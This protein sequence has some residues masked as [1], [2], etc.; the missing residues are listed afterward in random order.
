M[1]DLATLKV[2][3]SG[4]EEKLNSEWE[5]QPKFLLTKNG[6]IEITG[7]YNSPER[8]ANMSDLILHCGS[9]RVSRSDLK[10]VLTPRPTATHKPVPHIQI[11]ELICHEAQNRGYAISKEEYGLNPAGTKLFG[12]LRFHPEGHPEYSRALGFRN[13]H[14]KSM[15]VGLTVGLSILCCDNMA[16]GGETTIHRK[17]TSGIE[18]EGLIPQAF[19][20]LEHQ[21]IRLE[22]D[23]QGLKIQALSISSAKL[24]TVK[25]AEKGAINSSDIIPVLQ[26]F[27]K[28]RHEEFRD[29]NKWSLYNSFTEV[30]K[31]YTPARADQ[32]Y[33]KLGQLFDLS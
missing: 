9:E 28:P 31:K 12:V 6:L 14:D 27:R 3:Y 1:G 30:C 8:K 26:E 5:P 10:D 18:I 15:A 4:L 24:M 33:R 16:F 2:A 29:R 21:F 25:A 20:N 17:H 19:G 32:C 11:A 7:R 23:V 22:R 13:S